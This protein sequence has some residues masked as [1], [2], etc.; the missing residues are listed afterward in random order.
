MNVAETVGFKPQVVRTAEDARDYLAMADFEILGDN[1]GGQPSL[2]FRCVKPA[3]QS[4]K[5]IRSNKRES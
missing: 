5:Y 4:T 2:R 3:N 1:W